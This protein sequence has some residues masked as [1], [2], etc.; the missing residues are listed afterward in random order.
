MRYSLNSICVILFSFGFL[1]LS[2]QD[3]QLY[4]AEQAVAPELRMK[5]ALV[6]GMAIAIIKDNKLD[7]TLFYGLAN[8]NE[9]Q[10]V[11]EHTLFQAGSLTGTL[12]AIVTL[13]AVETGM[14]ELDGD[15]NTYLKQWQLPE[16][17]FTRNDPVTV[18]DILTKKRGFTQASKPKGYQHSEAIP[19]LLNI[20]N[21]EAPAKNKAIQ[22]RSGTHNRGNYSFETEVILQVLLEDIYQKPFQEIIKQQILT[23]LNM[24][25]S[26]ITLKPN[27]QQQS[28]L[29]V[30]FTK[31]GAPISDGYWIQPELAS[32]GLYTTAKD[33]AKL[34][35]EL[36]KGSQGLPNKLLNPNFLQ[37][38]LI[39]QN[40]SKALIANSYGQE[41][42]V[43]YGGASMG[44]RTQY[45]F[46]PNQKWGIVVFMNSHENWQF[47]NEVM[48]AV[49]RQYGL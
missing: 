33:F 36:L 27:E 45:E 8:P 30:G 43:F 23:P 38:A 11:N 21:G 20:L 44:Y 32:A 24:E 28:N 34:V 25:E 39:P 18:R 1:S 5:E 10:A 49:K 40:Q 47:M 12:T 9:N 19:T 42:T 2:A 48:W 22:L 16:N 15:I 14:I 37:E 13:Q 46:F 3:F 26:F 7:T 31:D 6:N 29:A 41:S 4:M 17:K 35:N